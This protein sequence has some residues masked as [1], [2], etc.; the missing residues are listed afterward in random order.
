[1]ILRPLLWSPPDTT[2]FYKFPGSFGRVNLSRFRSGG[3]NERTER[4]EA[5]SIFVFPPCPAPLHIV[6]VPVPK[7]GDSY[8]HNQLLFGISV[9]LE[10]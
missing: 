7:S 8:S 6:C 3:N 10:I 2:R 9:D 5:G 4:T 1:M